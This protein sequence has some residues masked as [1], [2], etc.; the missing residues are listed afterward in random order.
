M[1][2]CRTARGPAAGRDTCESDAPG[3]NGTGSARSRSDDG[4]PL[5]LMRSLLRVRFVRHVLMAG[6]AQTMNALL[7]MLSGI[8]VARAL[9]TS[10]K[11]TL[12]VLMALGSMA[13]L[14]GTLGVH[15]SAVY[16][17]GRFKHEAAD[18]VANNVFF[19]IC[20][21]LLT[22]GVLVGAGLV[23]S[24]ELLHEISSGLF[25]IYAASVPF[26]YFNQFGRGILFGAG[27]IRTSYL[28]QIIEGVG[29]L[30]GT[31]G[32]LVV[33]GKHLAPLVAIRIA[34]EGAIAIFLLNAIRRALRFR[35]KVSFA[36]LRRQLAY[37]L[38]NYASSLLWLFL[39]QSDIVLCN[40]FLGSGPTG[41][42]SVAVALGL[43]IT[44]LAATVGQLTF[45]R[46]SSEEDRPTRIANTNRALRVLV[47]LVCAGAVVV[48]A[49][50]WGL[51][52]LVYGSAFQPAAAA[53]AFLLPGFI[54]Y[55]LEIVVMNFLAGEGSPS[56]IVWA[57]L[58]GLIFNVVANL[59]VIPRWGINGAAAT[60][61]VGYT[62]VL[63][64]VGAYYRRSTGSL[65]PEMFALRRADVAAVMGRPAAAGRAPAQKAAA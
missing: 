59:F 31:I 15:I 5:L 23:F 41:V 1:P 52:P 20:G 14:L 7:A 62:I 8:V 65:L 61:S 25:V 46:V 10:G 60:S 32:V 16:F 6:G 48:G 34:I 37:G 13:V 19:G 43:P 50:S 42:Y 2:F 39:L 22:T 54:A 27:L 12:S 47:P 44:M 3:H 4:P 57:P 35:L 38:K 51:I 24:S 49:A 40:H 21:G 11:G 63:V 28:P 18:V 17:Q 30:V 45:Q 56:I 36:M 55:S 53:L 29:L 9:G 58:L 64:I 26:L 33:F